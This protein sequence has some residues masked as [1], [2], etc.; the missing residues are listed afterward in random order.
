MGISLV[1]RVGFGVSL[2]LHGSD[3]SRFRQGTIDSF[4]SRMVHASQRKTSRLRM[5]FRRYESAGAGLGGLAHLQNRAAHPRQSRP[6]IPGANLSQ[7]A[8]E[9]YLVG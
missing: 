9:F 7:A 5:E 4:V 2:R 8:A 1:C 3:R 6:G